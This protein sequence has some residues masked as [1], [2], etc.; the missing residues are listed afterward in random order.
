[1]HLQLTDH[2]T[3]PACDQAAGLILLADRVEGRRVLAGQLGCP[4][5]EARFPV[6]DGV[7][8]FGDTAQVRSQLSVPAMRVAALLGVTE[9][10]AMVLLI[11]PWEKVA[12]E[13]AAVLS[14]VEVVV[15]DGGATTGASERISVLRAGAR[16]PLR[17]GSMRGAVISGADTDLIAEAVRVVGLAARVVLFDATPESATALRAQNVQVVAEQD[18]TLVSVRVA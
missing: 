12:A 4:A 5:C 9:G 16:I 15:A 14:D 10:P 7:A 17:D 3:C 8:R 1:M 2:L 18:D 13:L 6:V 11:G